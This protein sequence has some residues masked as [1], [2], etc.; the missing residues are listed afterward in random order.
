MTLSENTS[1]SVPSSQ[2]EIRLKR[3]DCQTHSHIAAVQVAEAA[4]G[5]D[6]LGPK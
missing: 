2:S 4:D 3:T 1:K 6:N 5:R